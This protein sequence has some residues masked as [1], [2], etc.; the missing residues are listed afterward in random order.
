MSIDFFFALGALA[1]LKF[2]ARSRQPTQ[3]YM[4]VCMYINVGGERERARA[5]VTVRRVRGSVGEC[6]M[7]L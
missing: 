4:Y 2:L 3:T 5:I 1:K 6:K 7:S